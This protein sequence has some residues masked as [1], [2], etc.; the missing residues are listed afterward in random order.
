MGA[1]VTKGTFVGSLVRKCVSIKLYNFLKKK[2][3][4]N[5]FIL[6]YL[7]MLQLAGSMSSMGINIVYYVYID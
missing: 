5:L 1:G 7:M 6:T 3:Y 4:V 2:F